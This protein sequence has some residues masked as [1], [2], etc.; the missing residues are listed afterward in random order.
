MLEVIS[1]G[2]FSRTPHNRCGINR[3]QPPWYC[4]FPGADIRERVTTRHR[5]PLSMLQVTVAR[6][7]ATIRVT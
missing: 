5:K 3:R 1:I 4:R 7:P 2:Y 6:Y